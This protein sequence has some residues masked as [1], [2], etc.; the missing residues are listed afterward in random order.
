[1]AVAVLAVLILVAGCAQADAPV[2]EVAGVVESD[3][4]SQDESS[5]QASTAHGDPSGPA[6]L[7]GEAV[8]G[9]TF[10]VSGVSFDYSELVSLGETGEVP[11]E[12]GAIISPVLVDSLEGDLG[13]YRQQV[14]HVVNRVHAEGRA[15]RVHLLGAAYRQLPGLDGGVSIVATVLIDNRSSDAIIDVVVDAELQDASGDT[16]A[17]GRFV[18][19]Q[20]LYG[21]IP[22]ATMMLANLIF[23]PARIA[24]DQADLVD[25]PVLDAGVDWEVAS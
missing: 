13:L 4:A 11:E 6:S 14:Q 7:L 3:G 2:G 23:P 16:V 5:R 9:A 1:V 20:S 22:S 10:V 24:N 21:E 19:G 18:L 8:P 17:D 15:R 12:Y 25:S